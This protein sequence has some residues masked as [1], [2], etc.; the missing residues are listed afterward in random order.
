MVSQSYVKD[1]DVW[2]PLPTVLSCG[3]HK[4]WDKSNTN[5]LA[6]LEHIDRI[7]E[8]GMY[9]A[10][11]RQLEDIL[12]PALQTLFLDEPGPSGS[13]QENM[14]QFVA[15]RQLVGYSIAVLL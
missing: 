8:S 14:A 10:P 9:L 4:M 12:L 2:P 1:I 13:V 15:A 5:I 7:R 11:R 3:I 6:A